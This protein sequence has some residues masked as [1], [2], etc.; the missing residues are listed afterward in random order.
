MC[1]IVCDRTGSIADS[2]GRF[3]YYCDRFRPEAVGLWHRW[4]RRRIED[5]EL[6]DIV[7]VHHRHRAS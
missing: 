4:T 6:I 2:L 7:L 3:G 5:V 1:N